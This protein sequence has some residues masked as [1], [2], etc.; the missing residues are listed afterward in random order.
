MLSYCCNDQTEFFITLISFEILIDGQMIHKRFII[1]VF[2]SRRKNLR[3]PNVGG[4]RAPT[5]WDKAGFGA[6]GK[7]PGGQFPAENGRK[8]R[9]GNS[10]EPQS[11]VIEVK[12]SDNG[13]L[14]KENRRIM[15]DTKS[16]PICG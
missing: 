5:V 3:G 12:Q 7:L 10:N 9:A 11:S 13:E 2:L 4:G 16:P 15:I 6:P 1:S 8:P 14:W